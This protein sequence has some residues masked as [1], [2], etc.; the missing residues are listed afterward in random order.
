V[1]VMLLLAAGATHLPFLQIRAVE[2]SGT[3]TLATTT[4]EAYAL[5]RIKGN[6]FFTFPR[7]NIFLYPKQEIAQGLVSEHPE[8]E[9]VDVHAATF[10]SIAIKVIERQPKAHWCA[11]SDCY[12]MDQNGVVYAQAG[13][14][15][16]VKYHGSVEGEGWLPKQYLTPDEF[17]ALFALVDALS[18]KPEVGHVRDVWVDGLG[19]AEA[20]FESG[21]ILK[22]ALSDAGGDVFDRLNLALTAEPFTT[23]PPGNFEYLDLR[24][25]DKLYY[26]LK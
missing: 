2:V 22:F 1:F 10:H 14:E 16:L 23:N 18:Q 12:R 7:R 6:Y 8:L 3:Q 17:E 4:L 25:G 11:G 15:P 13:D 24:F 20:V 26:K 19:D 5:E 9:A 21:F